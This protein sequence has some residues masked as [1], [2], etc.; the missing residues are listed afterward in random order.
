MK[1]KQ[2]DLSYVESASKEVATVLEENNLVI[3]ESTVPPMT[4]K[5]MTNILERESGISRDKFNECTL[6]RESIT[7]KNNYMNQSIMIE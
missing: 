6:S 2:T 5:L 4:T 1:K 7:R 3:L